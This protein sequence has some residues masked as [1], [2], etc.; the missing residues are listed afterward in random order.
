MT[1]DMMAGKIGYYS[2]ASGL[3]INYS[4]KMAL[5]YSCH[6]IFT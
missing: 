3:E 2:R 6:I 5:S 1:R 4:K